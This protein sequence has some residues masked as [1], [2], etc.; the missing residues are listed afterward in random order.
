MKKIILI[1]LLIGT[2]GISSANAQFAKNPV[3][4]NDGTHV[5]GGGRLLDFKTGLQATFNSTTG[6]YELIA[7][8]AASV[9][10]DSITPTGLDDGSDT[11]S[12]GQLV[13][14][15]SADTTKFEYIDAPTGASDSD[16]TVHD[17]YPSACSAGDYVSAIGDTLTCGTPAGGGD[18]T[19]ATYDAATVSEQLV[20]LTATQTLTNKTIT[21]TFTGGLTGN[22]TGNV[23]GTSGST[24]GNAAT[25]TTITGL[26][27][28]T[29]TTQATQPSITSAANLATVG[30]IGTGVWQGTAINQTYLVG[31][32]GTNT[33]DNSANTTYSSL[34]TESTT[35]SAPLVKTTYALSIPKATTSV[36]GYLD[37]VDWDTFNNKVSAVYA[38]SAEVDTGTEASKSVTP[39]NFQASKRNIRW[40]VFNLVAKG[41]SNATA[42]NIAGDF[43]SPVAGTI[44]Q[45]DTTPF[46]L[47][48][49]NS[50]A[51]IFTTVGLVVDISLGGTSIMTT[52]KLDFD[53]TE[54]T[55]TTASTPP[56][57]TDTTIAVG[58]IITIDIDSVND[59][60]LAKGLT[61]YMAVRE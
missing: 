54:K 6:R 21:G 47:Y 18:M 40:L 53:T 46:Y 39:D 32:S 36:D 33:G 49:T 59:G 14:I 27:P 4:Y 10:E 41:T 34:V 51:G 57:L 13:A 17:S 30:T 16:W 22:V 31:Q 15:D 60:T 24:T 1:C 43:V 20:G 11:P 48:A 52:N 23:S 50:T 19:I 3:L 25:V 7:T 58:D 56:D 44:L 5:E 37:D 26:A 38:T 61:V 8:G 29:A 35:V 9:S 45:S 12:V 42:T 28:D 55:T 2:I